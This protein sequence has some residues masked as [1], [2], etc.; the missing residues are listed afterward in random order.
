MLDLVIR[1]GT[2]VD[3]TGS[4]RFNADVAVRD[5]RIVEVGAV[6]GPAKATIDATGKV[7]CPGFVDPHTHYDAQIQWDRLLS[8]SAEHGVTTAVIG[9]CGVGIAPCRPAARDLMLQDLVTVEGISKE[10]LDAGVKWDFETF[11]Q[12]M[13]A[14][15]KRGSGIN[16]AFLM[17]LA[18]L[19]MYAIGNEAA[20][21]ASTPDE[22]AAIARLI[23]E[24]MAAG[25]Y[26]FSSTAM[27][28]HV[29]HGGKPLAARLASHEELTTYCH[30]L[31][32]A[33]RG[34]IELALTKRFGQL[35]DDEYKLLELLVNE[36]GRNVT[37][38]SVHN[39]LEDPEA[40]PSVLRKVDALLKRGS[41]PQVLTRPLVS[42]M[43]LRRPFQL[44]E[45][46]A[47]K[48]IYDQSLERQMAI[49]A[50]PEFRRAFKE[51]L[52]LGRKFKAGVAG[53]YRVASPELKSL[54]GRTV[55]EVAA[56]RGVDP[57]DCLFDIAVEDH[58]GVTFVLPRANTNRERIPEMLRDSD[59]TLI[60][61]SDAGAHLD[62]FCEAGYTTYMLGH[63][64][65]KEKA[66][67]LEH[68]VK[69]MTS[70]PADF[71]G[72]GDRGRLKA[73]LAGDIV[74]FDPDTVGSPERGTMVN[75]LPAG[76]GRMYARAEGMAHVV[77]N[78]V[79]LYRQGSHTGQY[80]GTVLRSGK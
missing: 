32:K 76:G 66:L 73:G 53:I 12:Y 62:M 64:V 26:G 57:I 20:D 35:A 34:I 43:S 4:P 17:P 48:P 33:G 44:T 19:R 27:L 24:G 51:E 6:A 55:G 39:L 79:E 23:E 71:I 36:S 54:E 1:N 58:L 5:G 13:D 21:R 3:G 80:P 69:R 28:S 29:G 9:N 70:E 75:D 2:V 74:V 67:T 45:M 10:V 68:A 77:V 59:R 7:V 40:A 18:P 49:Y 8:S 15:A 72:I 61:L 52:K 22:A 50:D 16:L 25:A 63:W 42:E 46:T 78:G 65:R 31:R 38:L 37:W 56:E 41:R 11:P 47:C 30:V 60:G 14:A